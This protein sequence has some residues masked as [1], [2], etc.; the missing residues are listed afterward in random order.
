[1]TSVEVDEKFCEFID[2]ILL[3]KIK[4]IFVFSY[5]YYR[6]SNLP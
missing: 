2:A 3:V 1:M 4:T 5:D 6:N